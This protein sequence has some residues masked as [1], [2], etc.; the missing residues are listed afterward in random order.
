MEDESLV[1]ADERP[2]GIEF[3]FYIDVITSFDR[4]V[5]LVSVGKKKYTVEGASLKLSV[6]VQL[7][8]EDIVG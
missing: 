5:G 6:G 2:L 3:D 4:E 8:G 7:R 1:D